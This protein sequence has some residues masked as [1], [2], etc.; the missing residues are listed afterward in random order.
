MTTFT[1]QWPF[2][3]LVNAHGRLQSWETQTFP[4]HARAMSWGLHSC[5][6]RDHTNAPYP[7][8]GRSQWKSFNCPGAGFQLAVLILHW[9]AA[10]ETLT[11]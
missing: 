5:V 4:V 7:T 6:L 11:H 3:G 2:S 8:S 10:W 9:D 1:T